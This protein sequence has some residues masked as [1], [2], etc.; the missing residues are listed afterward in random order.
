MTTF[1]RQIEL[2]SGEHH[3]VDIATLADLRRQVA[4]SYPPIVDATIIDER[5][6]VIS[7][8]DQVLPQ[9]L[10]VAPHPG[11]GGE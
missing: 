5:G 6:N 4:E 10:I 11:W 7:E 2:P 1:A 9:H 8:T 3:T